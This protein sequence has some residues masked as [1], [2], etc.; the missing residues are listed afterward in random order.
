MQLQEAI[1]YERLQE[2]IGKTLRVLVDET[3]RGGALGR[4]S[5]DAPEIDGVV[6]VRKPKGMR[7]KLAPGEFVDVLIHDADAH[8]LWGEMVPASGKIQH[9]KREKTGETA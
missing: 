4:S 5:A 3:I 2:K 7:R 8:D 9:G 1:S 6:Y